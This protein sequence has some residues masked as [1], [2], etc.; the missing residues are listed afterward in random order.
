MAGSV[1]EEML[2]LLEEEK[3]ERADANRA[4]AIAEAR[5]AIELSR[6]RRSVEARSPGRGVDVAAL[7]RRLVA[8][9]GD[10]PQQRAARPPNFSHAMRGE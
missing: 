8:G 7:R 10:A 6:L 2:A 1:A 4:K 3:A 5:K 9:R